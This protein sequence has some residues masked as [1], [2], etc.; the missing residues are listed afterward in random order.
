[1]CNLGV[2]EFRGLIEK[3]TKEIAQRYAE[4]LE[5]VEAVKKR[6]D[7]L[8][9]RIS[10]KGYTKTNEDMDQ[11]SSAVDALNRLTDSLISESERGWR[12]YKKLER[13]C[14]TSAFDSTGL[15]DLQNLCKKTEQ[16]A[17]DLLCY[18]LGR[19]KRA[20]NKGI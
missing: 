16:F 20:R 7:A 10:N 2:V 5:A 19:F 8:E 18:S 17:T 13:D 3:S 14:Q 4:A 15:N 11:L 6:I 9:T 12:E 1:M